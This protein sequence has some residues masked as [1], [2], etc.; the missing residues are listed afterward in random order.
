M[1]IRLPVG[2]PHRCRCRYA[3][4]YSRR[5]LPD[6]NKPLSRSK[7]VSVLRFQINYATAT[8]IS[9]YFDGIMAVTSNME[10]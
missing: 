1:A 6:R 3:V 5:L 7:A 4:S 8:I 2:S 9:L 10:T